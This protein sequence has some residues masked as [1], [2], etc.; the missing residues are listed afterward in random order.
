MEMVQLSLLR[1]DNMHP[2]LGISFNT[3]SLLEFLLYVV[4]N[5]WLLTS[6]LF[7]MHTGHVF[8]IQIT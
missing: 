1:K 6:Q 7:I 3:S 2:C 8:Y 4:A 5:N